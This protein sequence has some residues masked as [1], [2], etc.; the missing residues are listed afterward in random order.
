LGEILSIVK[1]KAR[2]IKF[3]VCIS[4]GVVL[5]RFTTG[6]FLWAIVFGLITAFIMEITSP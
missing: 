4:I 2:F 6:G 5:G 1:N 3:V